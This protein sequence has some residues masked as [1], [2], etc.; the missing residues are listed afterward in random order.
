[1][2]T[3]THYSRDQIRRRAQE[4]QDAGEL[5]A[6]LGHVG[7]KVAENASREVMLRA[8]GV[9]AHEEVTVPP[10]GISGKR[11][12]GGAASTASAKG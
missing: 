11:S 10:A 12:A 1:M 9:E 8:A 6:Y 5:R 7:I 4:I 2:R 3:V